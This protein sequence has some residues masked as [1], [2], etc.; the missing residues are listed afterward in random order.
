MHKWRAADRRFFVSF[1][2]GG[3]TLI[4]LMIVVAILAIVAAVALPAYFGSIRK[5][6]RA[7]AVTLLNQTVQAQERWRADNAT[8]SPNLGAG[9]LGVTSAAT[10]VTTTG[11]VSS[12]QFNAPSGYYRVRVSTDSNA[13]LNQT[14]YTALATAIGT[15]A[16]DTRC[17]SLTLT[18]TGG[19]IAYT[20]TGT[21][22]ARECW[23]Q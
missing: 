20:S 6:R 19:T 21:A 11:T 4:E 1:R 16:N 10:V 2:A 15:Q 17:T 3:F 8:Y 22:A 18:M 13:N 5:S 9:G 14:S 7:D 12:S 23:S